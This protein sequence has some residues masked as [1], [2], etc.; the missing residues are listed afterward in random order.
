MWLV[1]LLAL[2]IV[3]IIVATTRLRLHPFLALLA[4]AFGF[5]LLSG[6]PAAEVPLALLMFN[7]GVETGQV[8]FVVTVSLLL[9]GLRRVHDG[10]GLLVARS[11]PYAIGGLAAFWTI[12][13][14]GAFL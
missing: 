9:Q 8:L 14:V 5:G 7:L 2:S 12:E 1:A 11:A 6:M 10:A 4:A 13:R 3:F